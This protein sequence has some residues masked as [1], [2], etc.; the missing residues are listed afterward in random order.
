MSVS[1]FCSEINSIYK[2][3]YSPDLP[4][5]TV[6]ENTLKEFSTTHHDSFLQCPLNQQTSL[7]QYEALNHK[8]VHLE[9]NIVDILEPKMMISRIEINE[10]QHF[11]LFSFLDS[12]SQEEIEFQIMENSKFV[13]L[14][15]FVLLVNVKNPIIA[16]KVWNDLCH[17]KGVTFSND[18]IPILV[19]SIFPREHFLVGTKINLSGFLYLQSPVESSSNPTEEFLQSKEFYSS[20]FQFNLI[21]LDF[22]P[23]T[24]RTENLPQIIELSKT[25]SLLQIMH[26]IHF[27]LNL[28]VRDKLV[29]QMILFALMTPHTNTSSQSDLSYF[30][31]NI[32]GVNHEQAMKIGQFFAQLK[33]ALKSVE[34]NKDSLAKKMISEKNHEFEVLE[35]NTFYT[36]MDD[37][38]FIDETKIETSKL[39]EV[40]T[41]NIMT[42]SQMIQNQLIYVKYFD[43]HFLNFHFDNSIVVFSKT[44]SVFSTKLKILW[45]EENSQNELVDF[46]DLDNSQFD[47]QE[48]IET[49]RTWT[50]LLTLKETDLDLIQGDFVEI[51][52]IDKNYNSEQF[53]FLIVLAKFVTVWNSEDAVSYHNYLEAK[54]IVEEISQR[55]KK[56]VNN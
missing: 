29:S 38:I 13:D 10:Q 42:L 2:L 23:E 45:Q 19:E 4:E 14:T 53:S 1:S 6:V 43:Q 15:R 8:L 36:G 12:V 22:S 33:L 24:K 31:L 17:K 39:N 41:L 3:H 25:G 49:L 52:K 28:I 44:R 27:K 37:S 34:I 35:L 30:N 26:M 46:G 9:G 51:R 48:L 21:L 7:S 11:R 55:D 40:E 47:F 32:F 18:K 16:N 54:E 56:Y 50:G 5:T 20:K